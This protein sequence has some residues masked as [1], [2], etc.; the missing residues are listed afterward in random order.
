MKRKRLDRR[1]PYFE[2]GLFSCIRG[3]LIAGGMEADKPDKLPRERWLE[4]G[5][6]DEEKQNQLEQ[7]AR[8]V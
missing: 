7:L 5:L 1:V 3:V 2:A 6:T 8:T 4:L